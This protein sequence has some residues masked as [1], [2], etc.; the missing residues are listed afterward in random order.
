M[1]RFIKTR[2]IVKFLIL[3]LLFESSLAYCFFDPIPKARDLE[4]FLGTVGPGTDVTTRFGHTMLI[5][6]NMS[7]GEEYSVSWGIFDPMLTKPMFFW[8]FFMGTL[9]QSAQSYRSDFILKYYSEDQRSILQNQINLSLDQKKKLLRIVL[10]DLK[11]APTTYS[12]LYKNCASALR[13]IIHSVLPHVLSRQSPNKQNKQAILSIRKHLLELVSESSFYSIFI[14]ILMNSEVDLIDSAWSGMFLPERLYKVLLHT[15][16]LSATGTVPTPVLGR[17]EIL[18]K[19]NIV[20]SSPIKAFHAYLFL[21][22]A[23]ILILFFLRKHYPPYYKGLM[24]F[25]SCCFAFFSASIGLLMSLNWALSSFT[26]TL[27]NANLWLFW[28]TDFLFVF[29]FFFRGM[30]YRFLT[31]Y[32]LVHLITLLTFLTLYSS[33]YFT[34]E[35]SRIALFLSPVSL[36]YFALILTAKRQWHG[37]EPV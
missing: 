24:I 37:T 8:Q 30:S 33:S 25:F 29:T 12:F 13:D 34:Q 15:K 9:Q 19:G 21:G 22:L 4:F 31:L 2:G 20:R 18:A 36:A 17:T 16:Q 11:R 6:K 5:V 1:N 14:D 27:H 23:F 32:T 35:V 28:P 3:S 10:S 26:L 7:T